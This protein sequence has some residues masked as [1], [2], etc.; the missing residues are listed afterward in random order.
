VA[1]AAD[2]TTDE[3]L[4]DAVALRDLQRLI[5]QGWMRGI[6]RKLDEIEAADAAA[7]RFVGRLRALA[8]R[9]EMNALGAAVSRALDDQA[10]PG[11]STDEHRS[12]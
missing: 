2:A 7:A 12:A 8:Q 3:T 5:D 6:Q 10:A 11:R 4:P 9:F 1:P